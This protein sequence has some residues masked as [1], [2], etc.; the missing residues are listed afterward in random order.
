M[1]AKLFISQGCLESGY[2]LSP[3]AQSA[4]IK[5]ANIKSANIKSANIK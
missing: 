1:A 2:N 5:S 4:N 3:T